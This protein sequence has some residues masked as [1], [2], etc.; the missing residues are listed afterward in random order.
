MTGAWCGNFGPDNIYPLLAIHPVA[1]SYFLYMLFEDISKFQWSFHLVLCFLCRCQHVTSRFSFIAPL[2][3]A[4]L[5]EEHGSGQV[6]WH[7]SMGFSPSPPG[8]R[9]DNDWRR[10][11]RVHSLALAVPKKSI[12]CC[13]LGVHVC[14]HTQ[15]T[16]FAVSE[17]GR[18]VLW[19]SGT[20][21]RDGASRTRKVTQ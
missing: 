7:R 12:K 4:S 11:S 19:K 10:P 1:L 17:F 13:R 8:K 20:N 5:E 9:L 16:G 6:T 21:C 14:I 18:D 2:F 15:Y 3:F